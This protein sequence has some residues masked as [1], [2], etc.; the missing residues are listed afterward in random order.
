MPPV[1]GQPNMP[2]KPKRPRKWTY[3]H[4]IE[5]E[6]ERLLEGYARELTQMVTEQIVT[7]VEQFRADAIE[8][9]PESIGWYER[10]RL[11]FVNA[12][13]LFVPT[14][15]RISALVADVAR[16]VSGFNK[17]QFHQVIRSAYGVDIFKSEP[18][19][20]DTLSV[21]EAENIKLIR[22]IP[23]NY[24][25]SLHGKV[26][27]AVRTGMAPRDLSRFINETYKM[28]RSRATLIARDQIGKLNGQLT[29]QRQT[30]IGIIEYTWRGVL[31]ERERP[32]H[33]AREGET[34]KW[35]DPPPDGHPGEAIQCRCSAAPILPDLDDLDAL[36]VH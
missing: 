21:F 36:I 19:L 11:A 29:E 35:S 32:E 13:V 24:L 10:L 33:V 9:I 20:P 5:H 17:R 28:P 14:T 26:V 16:Q 31:D 23:Q 30:S 6:Y 3:P 2:A 25:D 4:A 27:N 12:S 15:D 34:F 18:W 8:D 7:K 1:P 22:S